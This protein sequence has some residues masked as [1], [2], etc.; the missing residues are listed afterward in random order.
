MAQFK[1]YLK[2][3]YEVG[4]EQYYQEAMEKGFYGVDDNGFAYKVVDKASW[5]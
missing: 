2:S 4:S 3:K 1:E 5:K